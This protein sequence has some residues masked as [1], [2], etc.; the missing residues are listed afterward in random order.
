MRQDPAPSVS[1]SQRLYLSEI[2]RHP[3]LSLDEEQRLARTFRATGDP[4]AAHRLVTSN[5]RFVVKIA[6]EYRWYGLKMADLIQEGNVGLVKAVQKFDPE[7]GCR[8][9]TYAVWWIRACIH[10]HILGSW[11]LVRIGTTRAQRKLFFA[12][13]RTRRELERMSAT[14]GSALDGQRLALLA[15]EL[16]VKPCEVESMSQ[17]ID[18]RDLSL[19]TPAGDGEGSTHAELVA[20]DRPSHEQALQVAQEQKLVR[21]RIGAALARLDRRE[22]YIIEQRVMRDPPMTLLELARE[23]GFSRERARQVEVRAKEKLRPELE[24]LLVEIGWTPD[25]TPL[26]AWEERGESAA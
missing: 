26:E 22:R 3:L 10:H 18:G 7:R 6:Y 19:D 23:L 20:S 11:S 16:D 12:L 17:R 25:R 8:F 14:E 24:A 1:R 21:G 5:L 15:G 13:A 9:V 2:S 4:R